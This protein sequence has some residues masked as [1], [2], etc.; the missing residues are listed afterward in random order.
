[1][2]A[3]GVVWITGA[4][5]GIGAALA[6]EMAA[7][8]WQV[9][10]SGRDSK[11][12]QALCAQAPDAIHSF[13]LEVTD[14]AANEATA[15]A[16]EATL[17]PIDLAVFNAGV[18]S[19]FAIDRFDAADVQSRMQV[20]YGGTVNGIGAVLPRMRERRHGHIAL[21][22]SVAGFRGM[23]GSALFVQ[24]GD[25]RARR[26]PQAGS[27][28]LRDRYQRDHARLRTHAA[29]RQESVSHAVHHR[30]G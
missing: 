15:A 17:G 7:H 23:P 14:A 5:S 24:G 13:V 16:I 28:R 11:R 10:A 12:L 2:S 3:R 1:M 20:N 18:G 4:S 27:G 19:R 26:E 21:T 25:D 6:L 9:A 29:D 22:A 8:G 30:S